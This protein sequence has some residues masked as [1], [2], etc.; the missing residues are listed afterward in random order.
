MFSSKTSSAWCWSAVEDM[1]GARGP[2]VSLSA[3]TC[4][5][6]ARVWARTR[7]TVIKVLEERTAQNVRNNVTNE[8]IPS[9]DPFTS[10]CV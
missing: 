1:L 6:M 8:I 4:V 2:R 3:R 9:M 10:C 5:G 7:A